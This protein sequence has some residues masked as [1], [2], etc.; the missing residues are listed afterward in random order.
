MMYPMFSDIRADSTFERMC[1]RNTAAAKEEL[2]ERDIFS[3]F[4][5]ADAIQPC[6]GVLRPAAGPQAFSFKF[7]SDGKPMLC[8]V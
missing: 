8:G 6:G 5:A 7:G 1:D 4:L 2:A 3:Y